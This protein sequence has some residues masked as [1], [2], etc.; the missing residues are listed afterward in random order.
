M[1]WPGNPA[2]NL[3]DGLT[4]RDPKSTVRCE[5]RRRALLRAGKWESYFV[6]CSG[7]GNNLSANEKFCTAC[8]R[9]L[10]ASTTV[11]PAVSSPAAITPAETS[12]KAIAS[13]ACGFFFFLF[14]VSILAIVFGHLSLSEIRNS[15]GRLKGEG[16]AIAGLVLGY[17]GVAAIPV[18]IIAAIAIPNLLRARIAANESSAVA[19]VHAVN[20]AEVA[21]ARAHPSAGY[22]CMLSELADAQLIASPLADGQKNGYSFALQ[23]CAAD[24][25]HGP[26]VKYQVVAFPVKR[27][28]TGVRAFCSDESAVVRVYDNDDAQDCPL[29]G[30]PLQ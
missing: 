18:L 17:M 21:F 13:L 11:T 25:E 22:T 26:N 27:N 28:Q 16:V 1:L 19:S 14:P 30:S 2:R 20:T 6:L 3:A 15:A 10:S 24:T 12:G 9:P 29:N 8:G 7:C 23:G 5:V 4:S